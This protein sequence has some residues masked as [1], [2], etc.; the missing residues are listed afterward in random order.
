MRVG[1]E[2]RAVAPE[3]SRDQVLLLMAEG[4]QIVDVLP[5]REY[6]EDHLPGAVNL[7]LRKI[8]TLARQVLEP[9]RAVVVYCADSGWDLSPRAACRL[10]TLGFTEVYDYRTGIQDWKAAGLP[11]DGTNAARQSLADV[12]RRDVPTCSLGERVGDVRKRSAAAG[13]DACVVVSDDRVVLGLLRAAELQADPA[14]PVEQ[15]MRPGPSTYRPFVSVS[16]M[17]QIMEDR[18]LESS[19]VTTADGKL[20]GLVFRKDVGAAA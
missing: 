5:A 16:E 13:S 1:H 3:V 8:E 14:L 17:R 6:S 15:V 2:E 10:E 11:S 18:D 12:V 20:V 19:P 4:A 9:D 7:P